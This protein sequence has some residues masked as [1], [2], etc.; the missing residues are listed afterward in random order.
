MLTN[1]VLFVSPQRR[2]ITRSS[3]QKSYTLISDGPGGPV[4]LHGISYVQKFDE[5]HRFVYMWASLIIST[6][7]GPVFR[8]KGWMVASRPT[9]DSKYQTVFRTC[10]QVSCDPHRGTSRQ[11]D[12]HT[13]DL[14]ERVLQALTT[15]T[16]EC[17]QQIQGMLV[18]EFA[19]FQIRRPLLMTDS[20][21]L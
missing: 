3:Y 11:S 2:N 15:R 10:Y 12:V 16:R 1:F 19:G 6:D 17:H 14:K 18:D 21:F 20:R 13:E 4:A 8:E 7:S 5:P 9:G